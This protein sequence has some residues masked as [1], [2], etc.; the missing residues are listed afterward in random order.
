MSTPERQSRFVGPTKDHYTFSQIWPLSE[1]SANVDRRQRLKTF[2]LDKYELD[3]I[4]TEIFYF[5]AEADMRDRLSKNLREKCKQGAKGYNSMCRDAE[6]FDTGKRP[7]TWRELIKIFTNIDFGD[8]TVPSALK[9]RRLLTR[10]KLKA[11]RKGDASDPKMFLVTQRVWAYA[12]HRADK[13]RKRDELRR[14]LMFTCDATEPQKD[15]VDE[16]TEDDDYVDDD[17]HGQDD[18]EPRNAPWWNIDPVRSI[19]VGGGKS[20]PATL[21]KPDP[22]SKDESG[23]RPIFKLGDLPERTFGRPLG[24]SVNGEPGQPY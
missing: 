23:A 12:R 13:T 10:L 1:S 24:W 18:G 4:A 14:R 11:W 22:K 5:R 19:P 21:W 17:K 3:S 15:R 9:A 8:W 7:P 6:A 16:P 2:E 20:F